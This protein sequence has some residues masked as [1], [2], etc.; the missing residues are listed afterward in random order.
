MSGNFYLRKKSRLIAFLLALLIILV[1]AL[2]TYRNAIVISI[3]NYS[4]SAD[5]VSVAC[6]KFD[7]QWNLSADISELCLKHP[8]VDIEF[9]DANWNIWSKTLSIDILNITHLNVPNDTSQNIGAQNQDGRI[10]SIEL[11]NK[12]P[13]LDI[14][15]LVIASALLAAPVKV[16]LQQT[17][18]SSFKLL[19]DIE[20]EVELR[21]EKVLANLSWHI[22]DLSKYSHVTNQK[23]SGYSEVLDVD[24]LKQT[25]VISSIEYDGNN[26]SVSNIVD[27][28]NRLSLQNCILPFS[29]IGNVSIN[30]NI[31]NN[32][33]QID[34]SKLKLV[35]ELQQCQ[36]LVRIP[37]F[38]N[39]QQLIVNLPY[40]F[41]IHD[42]RITLNEVNVIIP[43][44]GLGVTQSS[45]KLSDLNFSV[46]KPS[47]L[48][49]V[50]SISPEINANLDFKKMAY[51]SA[52]KIVF[53]SKNVRLQTQQN[54]IEIV[55]SHN[56]NY[57][58]E[59]LEAAFELK[60]SSSD[61]TKGN[62]NLQ[63]SQLILG[64]SKVGIISSTFKLTATDINDIQVDFKNSL[65]NISYNTVPE[66]SDTHS[67]NTKV[68]KKLKIMGLSSDINVKLSAINDFA[69][70]AETKLNHFNI[71]NLPISRITINHQL[72]GNIAER[73]LTS[74]HDILIDNM[75]TAIIEQQQKDIQLHII[76]QSLANLKNSITTLVPDLIVGNGQISANITGELNNSDISGQIQLENVDATFQDY[77]IKETNY[78]NSFSI[79][80]AG[81]QLD[82]SNITINSLDA[83]IPIYNIQA[84]LSA[85]DSQL[86]LENISGKIFGGNFY[87]DNFW[88]DD[89]S[90]STEITLNDIELAKLVELQQQPGIKISG[91]VKGSLP[92]KFDE[93]GVKI[94]NGM[95]ISQGPGNLRILNNPA[96]DSIKAQQSELAFL[97][98]MNFTQLSSS[99]KLNSDGWLD[100]DFSLLGDN[101]EKNQN[102]K[103]NYSHQENILTLLKSLRLA[104]SV[105]KKIEKSLKEGGNK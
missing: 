27:L 81:L 95:L 4:S 36:S 1:V 68:E 2:I 103:F 64:D 53:D 11:L 30:T 82:P 24:A 12:L 65:N 55:D 96:F 99:V 66:Q 15:Q 84:S 29:A 60:F 75:F 45:L 37:E 10:P 88:L 3:I 5:S 19:G 32:S 77:Q 46:L 51:L 18:V 57:G 28:N 70:I 50:L 39:F 54:R 7:F 40:P 31:D 9:S 52:G 20:G 85:S 43:G 63:G 44:V 69:V 72:Q 8:K 89:R 62:G 13:L 104:N 33:T 21:N 94:E 86:K 48:N 26:I 98:N 71:A 87:L 79:D 105:Q 38:S 23:I 78:Q 16:E 14:K 17:T 35:A 74:S 90:Q 67:K 93:D 100:L 59:Q 22:S 80:S 91:E 97:E 61:V 101:P 34:L 76:D 56:Q 83:G 102:L 58:T 6:L 49:Y 73:T 92:L 47:T 42:N 25:N 41:N